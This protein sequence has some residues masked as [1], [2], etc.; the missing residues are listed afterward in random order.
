MV[1]GDLALLR[2]EA[3]DVDEVLGILDAYEESGEPF[4]KPWEYRREL[5][6]V[7]QV[8]SGKW[9]HAWAYLYNWPLPSH[10]VKVLSGDYVKHLHDRGVDSFRSNRPC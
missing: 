8:D 6:P 4:Q 7:R 10:T 3:A 9:V 2:S 1:F 5:V